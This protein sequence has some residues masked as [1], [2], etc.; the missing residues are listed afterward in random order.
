MSNKK[1]SW[2]IRKY[3]FKLCIDAVLLH[4]GKILWYGFSIGT[5]KPFIF[6]MRVAELPNN[7]DQFSLEAYLTFS[8]VPFFPEWQFQ[9]EQLGKEDKCKAKE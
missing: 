3:N 1:I 6:V 9:T 5:K 8:P 4:H 7:L 2:I